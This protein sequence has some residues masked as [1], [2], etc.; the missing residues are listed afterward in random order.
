MKG[1]LTKWDKI[2][3]RDQQ[4]SGITKS[5]TPQFKKMAIPQS[6]IS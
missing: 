3:I 2:N 5:Q 6:V 1:Q 4:K